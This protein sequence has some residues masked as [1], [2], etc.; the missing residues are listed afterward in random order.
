RILSEEYDSAWHSCRRSRHLI[1]S[2]F[3]KSFLQSKG[4][5]S[6]VSSGDNPVSSRKA[7][8]FADEPQP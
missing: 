4:E 3:G 8:A 1:N 2:K 7:E 6:K 5:V